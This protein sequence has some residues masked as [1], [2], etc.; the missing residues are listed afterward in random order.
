MH[1]M[2]NRTARLAIPI[3]LLCSPGGKASAEGREVYPGTPKDE[4]VAGC[5][6]IISE[7]AIF[8]IEPFLDGRDDLEGHLVLDVARQSAS[9]QSRSRQASGLSN[10]TIGAMTISMEGPAEVAI[11]L[12]VTDR[13]GM[14]LCEMRR[15][16]TLGSIP[17]KI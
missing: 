14:T 6:V 15:S 9:G 11:T 17:T 12:S 4:R 5:G 2:L 7:G 1:S 16:I 10:G 3:L 8:R 13:S